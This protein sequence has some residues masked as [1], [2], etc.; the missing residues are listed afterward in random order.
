MSHISL[1]PRN[2]TPQRIRGY[3]IAYVV[4]L[5]AFAASTLLAFQLR[6]DGVL[7]PA[8]FHSMWTAMA[9]WA[10]A[11][12]FTFIY[13]GAGGGYWRYTSIHEALRLVA[14][15]FVGSVLGAVVILLLLGQHGLPCSI[16]FLE[17]LV[18]SALVLSGRLIVRAIFS[19]RHVH[20]GK[21]ELTR[22]LIY[23]AGAAGLALLRELRQNQ[24]LMCDVIGLID[25]D[26]QKIGLTFHG[27]RVL[28]SGKD[29]GFWRKNI[30]SKKCSSP[31]LRRRGRRW[32][33]F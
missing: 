27:M 33:K 6:F 25:D 2:T 26:P 21:G 3:L 5:A 31:F 23:G 11:K 20:K 16:Y 29:L 24:S 15:N 7:P 18:S 13:G 19:A 9:I 14:T 10:C 4:D 12:S 32:C 28:G 30:S 22:T 8:Y 1:L 17:W